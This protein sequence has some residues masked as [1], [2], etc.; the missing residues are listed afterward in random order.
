LLRGGGE[1]F[2]SPFLATSLPRRL[3]IKFDYIVQYNNRK[4]IV[5]E[6]EELLDDIINCEVPQCSPGSISTFH[7]CQKLIEY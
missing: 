7:R 5:D 6:I 2:P 4:G 3:G 1:S